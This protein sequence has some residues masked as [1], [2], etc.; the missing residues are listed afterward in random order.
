MG[1]NPNVTTCKVLLSTFTGFR[2]NTFFELEIIDDIFLRLKHNNGEY[3]YYLNYFPGFDSPF[4][5]RYYSDVNTLT[6]ERNDMF[7]YIL[8]TDGYLQLFKN[9][10][11]GNKILTLSATSDPNAD[12]LVLVDIPE[13]ST[14]LRSPDNIIQINYSIKDLSVKQYSSWV[15]YDVNKQN[16]LTINENKS[17]FDRKDQYLLHAN[18][19]ESI[20][21]LRLNYVTLNNIRSEKNYIKRGTN[22]IDS[23]P[24]VPGVEFR[25]YTSLQTG[26]SQELG[27]DNIALTYVWYDKDILVRNGTDTVFTA[28]SS[29]YPYE[30]L[31]IN[32]TKFVENGSLAGLAPKVADNIYQLRK[33]L[34]KLQEHSILHHR[35]E[36]GK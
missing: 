27:T 19:N 32:D 35:V 36:G 8:D 4:F 24:Y 13:S 14:L 6:A 1:Q 30:K 10:T 33:K 20:N 31:N 9:T 12:K 7:R 17:I 28:P 23:T 16:D 15:S 34:K 2:N 26:N 25:D 21:D 29:L 11:Y 5:L 18:V 3:D 22:M